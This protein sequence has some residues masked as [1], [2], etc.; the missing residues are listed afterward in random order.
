MNGK[1]LWIM[2]LDLDQPFEEIKAQL[3]ALPRRYFCP[4]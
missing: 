3:L 2:A 4:Q 1:H